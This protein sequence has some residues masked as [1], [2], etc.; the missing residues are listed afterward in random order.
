MRS[1]WIN[2]TRNLSEEFH[3]QAGYAAFSVSQTKVEV[4]R[5]YIRL[6]AEHHQSMDYQDE[7]RDWLRQ[8]QIPWDERYLWE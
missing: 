3:W 6:Q 8:Y 7:L 5:E 4:V 1:A 2:Q